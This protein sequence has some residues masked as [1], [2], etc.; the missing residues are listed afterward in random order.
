MTRVATPS[1][2]VVEVA[3]RLRRLQR[4]REDLAANLWSEW[5]MTPEGRRYER[6]K[7]DERRQLVGR[8]WAW[9]VSRVK[10]MASVIEDGA[11][12]QQ[13]HAS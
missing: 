9:V 4:L 2:T 7:G 3:A 6:S 13:E 10:L 1:E 5:K 12:S 8:G 11:E